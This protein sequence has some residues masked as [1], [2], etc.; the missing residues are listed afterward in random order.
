MG[1]PCLL[2]MLEAAVRV[3]ARII[4]KKTKEKVKEPGAGE[5]VCGQ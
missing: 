4:R 5:R 3:R 2:E 1:E